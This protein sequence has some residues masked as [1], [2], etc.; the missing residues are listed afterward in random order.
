VP[1]PIRWGILGAGW[2]ADYVAPDIAASDGSVLGAVAARDGARAAAFA[3]R[4]GV[5]R[6][7][8]SYDELVADP[9]LDVI[10]VAT[11]HS[12]H[13][14]HAL[15]A[16]EAGK[17]VL[18]EKA[19][20]LNAREA[21]EVVAVARSRR[22]FCMEA[23]WMRF[24]PLIV[25]AQHLV[26]SGGIG[27]LVNVRGDY[28][29]RFTYDPTHRLFDLSVGGG[30][31]LDLGVY[32]L[33][34]AWLFLGRPDSVQ[35]AGVL[36]PTGSD[37]TAAV[38]WSY[39]SGR[40]AQIHTSAVRES[41]FGALV[42]GT[43]GWLRLD[44]PLHLPDTMTIH[45]ADGEQVVTGELPGHGYGLEVAEV[46]RCLRAG[47]LESPVVP[48]DETVAILETIDEARRQI[49]VRYPADEPAEGG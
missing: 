34:F 1:E 20:T 45:T 14:Q 18:V 11:T 9:D 42:V 47:E 46:E 40:V 15:L 6:S 5:A 30:A 27:E 33:T 44:T 36:S 3:E 17:P 23:M 31:L 43:E 22:L 41:P 4:H 37:A 48:L 49:G 13:H 2:I 7:Y 16:L 39:E 26:S 35:A 19:F 25:Q 10:Y 28:S 21:R 8:G 29:K 24:N 38:Q 32:P 12:H